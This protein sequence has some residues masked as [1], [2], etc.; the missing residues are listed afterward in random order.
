MSP[1]GPDS[2]R[3][4]QVGGR[5]KRGS[6]TSNS[7]FIRD[8]PAAPA[9]HAWRDALRAAGCPARLPA[10]TVPVTEA[11]GLVTVAP[12]R[13]VASAGTLAVHGVAVRPG[14]PVVLG[15]VGQTP[16]LSA[17]GYPVS[18]ALAFDI[19][20]VPLLAELS[21]PQAAAGRQRPA[22]AQARLAARPGRLGAGQ[23]RFLLRDRRF[24]ASVEALGGYSAREMGRR[25]RRLI[26]AGDKACAG[27]LGPP[28]MD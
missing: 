19:F 1:A 8:V 23:A 22:G 25:P 6:M 16:L 3:P 28:P 14:H 13:V 20:A 15:V 10:V 21:V 17:P 2:R 7:P 12:A 5:V 4:R 27:R 18:A 11:A 9:L 24:Q 26:V